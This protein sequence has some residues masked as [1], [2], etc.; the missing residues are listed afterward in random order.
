MFRCSHEGRAWCI[1]NKNLILILIW[2]INKSGFPVLNMVV[3]SIDSLKLT[4]SSNIVSDTLPKLFCIRLQNLMKNCFMWHW[5]TK[6][7]LGNK[8]YLRTLYNFCQSVCGK[9]ALVYL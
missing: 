6:A 2:Y 4:K 9:A 8:Q 5:D 1:F 3:I 7:A